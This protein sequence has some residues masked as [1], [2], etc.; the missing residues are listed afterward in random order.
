MKHS[1]KKALGVK[2]LAERNLTDIKETAK[3]I[4]GTRPDGLVVFLDKIPEGT[5]HADL[6]DWLNHVRIA[7][8]PSAVPVAIAMVRAVQIAQNCSERYLQ[9]DRMSQKEVDSVMESLTSM[10]MPKMLPA[11]KE[12]QKNGKAK[13]IAKP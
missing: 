6:L 7:G 9:H 3:Y 5:E 13:R 11:F 4:R 10:M 8:K 1:L 2:A 12:K